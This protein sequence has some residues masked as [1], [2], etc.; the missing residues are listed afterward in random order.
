MRKGVLL[1]LI[2]ILCAFS[3][4]ALD[5]SVKVGDI[6]THP[7]LLQ[8]FLPT[9]AEVGVSYTGITLIPCSRTAVE[10]LA[11]GAYMGREIWK[12]DQGK[13][14]AVGTGP[15]VIDVWTARWEVSFS[16]G[17]LGLRRTA[18]DLV[19]LYGGYAGRW[20]EYAG[21]EG[22]VYDD[23]GFADIYPDV[24]GILS[25]ALIAGAV[26]DWV[27]MDGIIPRGL[28]GKAEVTYAPSL[29]NRHTDYALATG[30]LKGYQPL[31]VMKD[32]YGQNLF[33][34]Y[35]ANRLQIDKF[36]GFDD[37]VPMFALDEPALGTKMR[38]MERLSRS[39]EL[40]IV[41]NF[42][43]RFTGPELYLD[44]VYP[45]I[46]LFA[47]LGY[48]DGKQANIPNAKEREVFA[49]AGIEGGVSFFDFLNIGYRVSR[50]LK[51]ENIRKE[52]A[53]HGVYLSLIFK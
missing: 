3:A 33:A 37:S 50:M 6:E 51:G 16:Q 39:G 11:G 9:M 52:P 25:H 5:L 41:N 32:D 31:V 19:T 22:T 48:T 8:G 24:G 14:L 20:E 34:V 1:A 40:T 7:D 26:I 10:V 18:K 45:R 12:D 49:S 44:K 38:G 27:A 43:I 47:D 28:S 30:V 35:L 46:H 36:F 4:G 17:F 42:D 2:G 21:I 29:I 23:D 13:E 53:V 15:D